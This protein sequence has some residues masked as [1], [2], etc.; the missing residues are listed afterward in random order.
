M[1]IA[2][3]ESCISGEGVLGNGGERLDCSVDFGGGWLSRVVKEAVIEA[4]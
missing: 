2:T 4:A 1:G 3:G